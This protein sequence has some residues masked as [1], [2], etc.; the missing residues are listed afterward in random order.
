M[1]GHDDKNSYTSSPREEKKPQQEDAQDRDIAEFGHEAGRKKAG[2][3]SVPWP[4]GPLRKSNFTVAFSLRQLGGACP[5]QLVAY[6]ASRKAGRVPPE[7][8]RADLQGLAL[9][10]TRRTRKG[11]ADIRV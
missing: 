2:L 1:Y 3:E 6:L 4:I 7:Q 10:Y 5:K 9:G 11:S 8:K